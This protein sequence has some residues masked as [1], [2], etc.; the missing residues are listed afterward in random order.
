MKHYR[1]TFE[2]FPDLNLV[3]HKVLTAEITV[4][5]GNKK[6]AMIRALSDIGKCPEFSG[7]YKNVLKIEEVAE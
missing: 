5:A 2:I 1:V 4:E 6:L 7:M 3:A